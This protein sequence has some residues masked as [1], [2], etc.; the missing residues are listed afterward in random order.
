M[1]FVQYKNDKGENM[2]FSSKRTRPHNTYQRL[3]TQHVAYR[4]YQI[5]YEHPDL[6]TP[7]DI[8]HMLSF[9][10]NGGKARSAVVLT[11][12]KQSMDDMYHIADF[13]QS[14]ENRLSDF[15]GT[16]PLEI[17]VEICALLNPPSESKSM[18]LQQGDSNEEV[19]E[20]QV[21]N[22]VCE[23][24][25]DVVQNYKNKEKGDADEGEN[26]QCGN[27][28]GKENFSMVDGLV[29]RAVNNHKQVLKWLDHNKLTQSI[30]IANTIMQYKTLSK[31]QRMFLDALAIVLYN[32][33]LKV[34]HTK[35]TTRHEIKSL[36]QYSELPKVTISDR[37]VG[38]K[39]L[40]QKKLLTKNLNIRNA[41]KPS[42]QCLVLLI[43]DSGSMSMDYKI[44]FVEAIC[45]ERALEVQKGNCELYFCTFCTDIHVGPIQIKSISEAKDFFMTHCKFNHGTTDIAYAIKQ[46]FD[47]FKGRDIEVVV[48]NDGQDQM[49]PNYVP[50]GIVHAIMLEQANANLKQ[51]VENSGGFSTVFSEISN[52]K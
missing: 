34:S 43:D 24:P 28:D 20:S 33:K 5:G 36:E 39:K 1:K 30:G 52:R 26:T 45:H 32:G 25:P 10:M 2:M 6:T 12:D 46:V 35:K 4:Y 7:V 9:V 13:V 37:L 3:T 16:T 22:E 41:H 11:G 48:I 47:H 31:P 14:L 40:F 8:A 49:D 19:D 15:Q 17:A 44:A 21:S 23:L 51:V 18:D 29:R 42:K 38:G 27:G 50:D